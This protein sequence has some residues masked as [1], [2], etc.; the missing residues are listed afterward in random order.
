MTRSGESAGEGWELGCPEVLHAI[1][2]GRLTLVI[3]MPLSHPHQK[4][5][6][7]LQEA[8][9]SGTHSGVRWWASSFRCVARQEGNTAPLVPVPAK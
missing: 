7:K 2:V 1:R 8:K 5:E 4:A 9:E 3:R 6:A